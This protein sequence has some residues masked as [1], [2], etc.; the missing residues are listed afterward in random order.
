MGGGGLR[1]RTLPEPSQAVLPGS[2][3]D[4][5]LHFCDNKTLVKVQNDPF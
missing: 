2:L 5:I 3:L 1:A 4:T